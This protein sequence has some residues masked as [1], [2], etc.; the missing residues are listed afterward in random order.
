MSDFAAVKY[1]A[2]PTKA[3]LEHRLKLGEILKGNDAAIARD[4]NLGK[5][6][7]YWPDQQ[8]ILLLH[9]MKPHVLQARLKRERWYG[10]ND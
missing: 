4:F 10:Q 1:S 7:S 2:P 5:I 9:N 6:V 3:Q 8:P